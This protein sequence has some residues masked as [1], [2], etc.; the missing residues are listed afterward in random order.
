MTVRVPCVRAFVAVIGLVIVAPA[1]A[2]VPFRTR[3][4]LIA[5]NVTVLDDKGVPVGGLSRDAFTVTEDARPQ[6]IEHFARD[7]V[8]ISLVVAL[9][10]SESMKG[11]RFEIARQAVK[12]FVDRLG[13]NDEFAVFGFNDQPFNIS[14]WS[15]SHEAIL[16]AL[17]RVEPQGYTALYAAVSAAVDGLRGS[18]NRRQALVIVSHGNDQLRGERPTG[19]GG[20]MM[21]R[22]RAL[23]A[24]EQ[25]QRSEAVVYAIGVDTPDVP[26]PYRLDVAALRSLTDPT[27]GSTRVVHSDGAIVGA[28][29]R[30][31][32]EL[33]RQYVIGFVLPIPPMASFTTFASP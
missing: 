9:D 28:A 30:I 24:I 8:P 21:A 20:N 2:Q 33:R 4:D 14:L 32:D 17:G 15:T 11:G 18:R 12:G 16:A 13:A 29:G 27:G 19:A 23:S 7:D 5:L 26:P 25:V 10:S 1:S 22:Q 3:T 6:P 31:G